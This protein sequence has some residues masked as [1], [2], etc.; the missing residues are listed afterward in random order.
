M[1]LAKW[2]TIRS[3]GDCVKWKRI[4]PHSQVQLLSS[5]KAAVNHED[6]QILKAENLDLFV[7]LL[8]PSIS[9]INLQGFFYFTSIPQAARFCFLHFLMGT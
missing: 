7:K 1:K 4:C 3:S 9:A 6:R 5:S 2:D 8:N